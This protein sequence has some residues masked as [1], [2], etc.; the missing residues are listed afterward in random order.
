[1]ADLSGIDW[2]DAFSNAAYIPNGLAFPA[3]WQARAKAF[4]NTA[5]AQLDL[6]YG[7]HPRE[8]L[9]LFV[10]DTKPKGLCVFIHGGFWIDFDKSSWSDLAGGALAHG[11][12]VVLPSYSLAPQARISEITAQIGRAI[13]YTAER[14]AGPICLAGHS[15]G[16]HLAMR[17]VCSTSPLNANIAKGIERVVSI[18]GVHD[19]RALRLHSM[20]EKL[21]LDETEAVAESPALLKPQT[22]A[23]ITAWVGAQERPEFL[24]QSSLLREAW[25]K[26]GV[27]IELVVE[28]D[29]HHFDVIDGLKDPH[30]PLTRTL[31]G[32]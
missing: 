30:H 23:K 2:E 18:S 5:N 11:W 8:R 1:M 14:I 20:N 16:G 32:G 17:M 13:S 29:R 27:V 15:A 24:R 19:L 4:R 7:E 10:P 12:A 25:N 31:I 22:N 21:H 6:Q 3:K 28:A 9:D 26:H